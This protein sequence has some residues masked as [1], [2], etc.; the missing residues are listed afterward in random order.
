MIDTWHFIVYTNVDLVLAIA[1]CTALDLRRFQR[2][3][4]HWHRVDWNRP[5]FRPRCQK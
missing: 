5:A 2:E 4:S 1:I 3:A